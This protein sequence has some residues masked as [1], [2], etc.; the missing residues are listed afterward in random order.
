MTKVYWQPTNVLS[1]DAYINYLIGSRGVGKTYSL[2]IKM[3]KDYLKHGKQFAYIRRHI[4]EFDELEKFFDDM[5]ENN[6]FPD[7]KLE[8]VK[9][10]NGGYFTVNGEVCGYAIALRRQRYHKSVPYPRLYNIM[11]DEFII[12][13][14]GGSGYLK[15][16]VTMF[17]ELVQSLLRKRWGNIYMIG[18]SLSISNPYFMY[19]NIDMNWNDEIKVI[20]RF[21]K[22]HKYA[23]KPLILVERV[24]SEA[25]TLEMLD[26]PF[27]ELVQDTPYGNYAMNNNFL[28]DQTG[29][30]R[31]KTN[32]ASCQYAIQYNNTVFGLWIDYE[33]SEIYVSDV[34]VDPNVQKAVITNNEHDPTTLYVGRSHHRIKEMKQAYQNGMLWFSSEQCYGKFRDVLVLVGL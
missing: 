34:Q 18:N 11:F 14:D 10:K 9:D 13:T 5:I 21:S 8:V 24:Y 22:K 3:V 26:S 28:R 29:F 17:L 12:D 1:Y 23:G 15:N 20:K 27:G 30:V 19:W 32:K 7:H 33:T 4:T 16:E 6:E 25:H 2:T 31:K